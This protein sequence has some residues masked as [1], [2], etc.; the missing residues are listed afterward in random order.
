MPLIL[1]AVLPLFLLPS[2]N[3]SLLGAAVGIVSWLVFLVD[4]TVHRAAR[5][6]GSWLGR[7]DLVRS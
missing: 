1:S 7:F 5:Q 3:H 6:L 2:G 4:F